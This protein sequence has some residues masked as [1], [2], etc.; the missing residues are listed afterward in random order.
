MTAMRPALAGAYEQGLFEAA[1]RFFEIVRAH[2]CAT[3]LVFRCRGR[4]SGMTANMAKFAL[5]TRAVTA[6]VPRWTT[7]AVMNTWK[8][9]EA[10]GLR[11]GG[12]SDADPVRENGA[13]AF[14]VASGVTCPI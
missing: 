1:V 3:D 9:S 6:R 8:S 5:N 2:G 4:R 11:G 12:K 14:D 13:R 7:I 10:D